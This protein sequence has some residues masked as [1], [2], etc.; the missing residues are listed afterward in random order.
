MK[1]TKLGDIKFEALKLMFADYTNDYSIS[2]MDTYLQD[3]N[4]GKYL[5]AMNGSINRCF[6]RLRAMKKQPKKS[7]TLDKGLMVDDP[8]LFFDLDTAAFTSVDHIVRITY[9]DEDGNPTDST[10]HYEIEGRTLIFKNL[11]GSFRLIYWEKLPFI[12]TLTD[13]SILLI[14]DE[15]A[16]LLPIFIK[17]E[18]IEEDEPDLARA[19][20]SLFEQSLASLYQEEEIN[21]LKVVD[22]YEGT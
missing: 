22:V 12:T 3:N 20:R 9:R 5:R 18:L 6:D 1:T 15:L 19:A 2:N 17:S 10:I 14:E 4:Y 16:R 7:L 11:P 8:Y 21:Q 13:D